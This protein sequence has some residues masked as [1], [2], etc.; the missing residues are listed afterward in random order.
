MEQDFQDLIRCFWGLDTS[1]CSEE[2]T[3]YKEDSRTIC[4]DEN[5]DNEIF[6]WNNEIFTGTTAYLSDD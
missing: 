6:L 3:G 2:R 5:A 1:F 4:G